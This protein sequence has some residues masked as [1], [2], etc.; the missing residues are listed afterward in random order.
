MLRT[1]PRNFQLSCV[2]APQLQEICPRTA[3]TECKATPRED[4]VWKVGNASS[5]TL[6]IAM[7]RA[8]LVHTLA[9]Q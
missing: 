1:C 9:L 5:L 6:P 3:G 7:C 8:N 4:E 2:Q